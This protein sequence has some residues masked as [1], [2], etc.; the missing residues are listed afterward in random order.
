M[1]IVVDVFVQLADGFG[2]ILDSVS[3][4]AALALDAYRSGAIEIV[5]AT[6]IYAVIRWHVSNEVDLLNSYRVFAWADCAM[7]W[8]Q[9]YTVPPI[10]RGPKL[11]AFPTEFTSYRLRCV[12][13]RSR[14]LGSLSFASE[15]QARAS[16]VPQ[17]RRVCLAVSSFVFFSTTLGGSLGLKPLCRG[18]ATTVA[19]AQRAREGLSATVDIGPIR[20]GLISHTE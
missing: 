20:H 10:C 12:H 7:L 1:A 14:V 19:L 3:G 17:K 2:Y 8:N 11:V 16:L 5:H 9:G 18:A 6:A 15:L 13:I 4:S